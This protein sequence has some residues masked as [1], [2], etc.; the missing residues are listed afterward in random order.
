MNV[1]I[2]E[3]DGQPEWAVIPYGEYQQLLQLVERLEPAL[4]DSLQNEEISK[5]APEQPI[6]SGKEELLPADFVHRLVSGQENP[7]RLWREY[8]GFTQE[9]LAEVTKVGKSHISQLEMGKKQPS[10]AVLKRLA[11]AL[12]VEPDDLVG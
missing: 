11:A 7:L 10:P 12:R 3:K 8:R 5:L 2:I 4:F 1:Q 9:R 6:D